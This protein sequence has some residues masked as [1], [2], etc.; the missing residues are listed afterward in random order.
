MYHHE[1]VVKLPFVSLVMQRGPSLETTMGPFDFSPNPISLQLYIL[2]AKN[3]GNI[4][5]TL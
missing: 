5:Y 1:G 2:P 4:A 3:R